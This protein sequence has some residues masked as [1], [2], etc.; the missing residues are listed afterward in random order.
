MPARPLF[1]PHTEAA[2]LVIDQRATVAEW[3]HDARRSMYCNAIRDWPQRIYVRTA[4]GRTACYGLESGEM[5][6]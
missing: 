3:S 4:D 2:G 1:D 5:R 6:R